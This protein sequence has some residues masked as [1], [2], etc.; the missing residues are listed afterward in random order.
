MKA[1]S[2]SVSETK[3]VVLKVG[4][5]VPFG[6]QISVKVDVDPVAG[7][8]NTAN[9]TAT[10]PTRCERINQPLISVSQ[11]EAMTAINTARGSRT[12]FCPIPN[13][14]AVVVAI[15]AKLIASSRLTYTAILSPTM[16][17]RSVSL[18]KK[19]V[20]AVFKLDEAATS[21]RKSRQNSDS[22]NRYSV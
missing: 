14:S 4:A 1:P 9:N 16:G 15:T 11:T 19:A 7:E 17:M 10:L 13:R 21:G 22:V 20:V 5:L 12:L 18:L 6:E 2:P 3:S 8:T